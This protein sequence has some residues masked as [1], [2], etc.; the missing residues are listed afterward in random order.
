MLYTIL[1]GNVA[2][3]T[4]EE[5]VEGQKPLTV[6]E[7]HFSQRDLADGSPSVDD[8]RNGSFCL[9]S[10]EGQQNSIE[11][12]WLRIDSDDR[13]TTAVLGGVRNESVLP[14]CHDYIFIPEL[15][16]WEECPIQQLLCYPEFQV[17]SR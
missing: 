16:C 13:L 15:E 9:A 6:V 3:G 17:D 14:E 4:D 2:V 1:S 11:P 7:L 10:A 8:L 12:G 5:V